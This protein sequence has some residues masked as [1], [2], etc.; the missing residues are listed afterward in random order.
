MSLRIK[1]V[2]PKEIKVNDNGTVIDLTKINI[3]VKGEVTRIWDKPYVLSISKGSHSTVTVESKATEYSMG[4]VVRNGATIY[5]GCYLRVAVSGNTGY[6][7]KW[8]LNGVMQTANNVTV[9]VL[10]NVSITVDEISTLETLEQPSISGTFTFDTY[11]GFNYL[12]C[13]IKNPN[14][15]QVDA[16]ILVYADGGNL[17]GSWMKKI[18]ANSTETYNHGEMF[19]NGAR[20]YVT[21]SCSG[22]GSSSA[23]ATFGKYTGGTDSGPDIDETTSTTTA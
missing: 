19:C 8:K 9:Q 23:G 20:V 13:K 7:V 21:F 17:D 11:G 3:S 5:H 10:G 14:P 15:R 4:E 12:S 1:G 2:E 6:E 18:S 22:Y 16:N